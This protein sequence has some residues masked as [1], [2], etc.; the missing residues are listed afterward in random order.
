MLFRTILENKIISIG[1]NYVCM[2]ACIYDNKKR[3]WEF[4][5]LVKTFSCPTVYKT[6]LVYLHN[7]NAKIPYFNRNN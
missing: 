1:F 4:F 5:Q 7:C 2:Y 3:F 6:Y